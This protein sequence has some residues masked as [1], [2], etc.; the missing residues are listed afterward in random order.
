MEF[1]FQLFSL[2]LIVI[3]VHAA[4]V[5]II[6]PNADAILAQQAA[7]IEK[8][9]TQ[10]TERSIYVLIRDYE[11]AGR[12]R[13][14]GSSQAYFNFASAA[15]RSSRGGRWLMSW[16]SMY[17]MRP[18]LSMTMRARSVVPLLRRTP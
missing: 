8:N 6:R 10:S 16:T 4:Y 18:C 3:V 13:S 12:L 14:Q 1:I 17:R 2:I 5:G 9:K 7:M 15:A 11:Q